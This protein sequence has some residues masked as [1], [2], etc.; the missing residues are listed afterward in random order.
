MASESKIKKT[1]LSSKAAQAELRAKLV[2]QREQ[3]QRAVLFIGALAVLAV[4]VIGIVISSRPPDTTLPTDTS[5]R[6]AG[7]PVGTTSSAPN[8]DV[9][10]YPVAFPYMGNPNAPVRIEE[11][12][13]FS[14]SYCLQYHDGTVVKIVDEIRAGRAQFVYIPTTRTGDYSPAGVLAVTEAAVCAMQQ[15]KFWEMHDILFD[16]QSRYAEGAADHNRL[17]G[18]AGQ[19]GMDTG[20]FNSCM[21]DPGTP[22]V[23]LFSNGKQVLPPTQNP[24]ETPGSMAGLSIGSLRGIMEAAVPSASVATQA[25]TQNA[26]AAPTQSSEISAF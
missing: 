10:P 25:A 16:W 1:S 22:T 2:R 26:T 5:G 18:A 21:S 15:N 23:F 13:S 7:I 8:K 17:L 4:I 6:Y 19:L 3:Q 12:S 9:I 20:K 11:I 24:N 14:C